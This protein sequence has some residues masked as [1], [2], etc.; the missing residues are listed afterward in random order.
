[1]LAQD[2]YNGEVQILKG[3]KI[4]VINNEIT[5]KDENDNT[6]F[7]LISEV[8]FNESV[9]YKYNTEFCFMF[10]KMKGYFA[11]LFGDTEKEQAHIIFCKHHKTFKIGFWIDDRAY[12]YFV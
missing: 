8:E 7:R 12:G 11:L 10:R 1:M 9:Y 6:L 5:I 4:F 2:L 3:G